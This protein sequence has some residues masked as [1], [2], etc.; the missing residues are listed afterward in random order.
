MP[1]AFAPF[2]FWWLAPLIV[3]ATTLLWQRLAPRTAFRAGFAFGFSAFLAGTYWIYISVAI[4]GQAPLWLALLLMLGLVLIMAV[5]YGA[6]GWT[7]ARLLPALP[8]LMALAV[9]PACWALAEWARGW[10]LS[11]FPWLSLGYSQLDA[12]YTGLAPLFGVYG[13][14][15]AVAIVGVALTQLLS[16]RALPTIAAIVAI[17]AV[18]VAGGW[19]RTLAFSEPTGE[20]V[21]VALVQGAVTQDQKWL[22]EQFQPT[23]DLYRRMTLASTAA[24]VVI[25]PEVAMPARRGQLDAYFAELDVTLQRTDTALAFGIIDYDANAQRYYN[26][27]LTEGNAA[28]R[29]RKHHLVPFGEYFP[30]PSFIREWMK[31]MSL[32]YADMA[33][34]A[35]RQPPMTLAGR[36]VA[37]SIC[38]EDAFATEQHYMF[39]AAEYIVNITNDAWFGESIAPYH[40]L[41]IARFRSLETGRAQLRVA[42]TGISAIIGPDGSLQATLGLFE[43]NVLRGSIEPR[44]GLTPYIRWGNIPVVTFAALILMGCALLRRRA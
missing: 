24:D 10:I 44:R 41:D 17:G 33:S 36:P 1:L 32:P 18:T 11:G 2:G 13:V 28:G 31:M 42:N 43:E 23:L 4:F 8:P 27:M 38:Y 26:A 16:R 37:G 40:H 5:Y 25:W 34:G 39:P 35:A 7:L 20:T 15:V 6:I 9:V 22:P 19:L 3:A 21:R 12:P 30:V 14:S 29:Y